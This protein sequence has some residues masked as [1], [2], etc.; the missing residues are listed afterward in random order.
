MITSDTAAAKGGEE[1]PA[2]REGKEVERGREDGEG[3][4]EEQAGRIGDGWK[5]RGGK[6]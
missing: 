3:E 4:V 5:R 2:G 1:A 6:R